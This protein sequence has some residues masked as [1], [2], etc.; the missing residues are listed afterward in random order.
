M[1]VEVNELERQVDELIQS[2]PPFSQMEPAGEAEAIALNDFIFMSKGHAQ[3]DPSY[4]SAT[5]N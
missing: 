5:E 4:D 3:L 1:E 2:R